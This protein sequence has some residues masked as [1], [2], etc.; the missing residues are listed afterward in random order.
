M[1]M[2]ENREILGLK[3]NLHIENHITTYS[4]DLSLLPNVS[5]CFN[6]LKRLIILLINE[7]AEKRDHM[8]L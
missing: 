3:V 5:F 7:E 4:V 1:V 6:A 2:G 8:I